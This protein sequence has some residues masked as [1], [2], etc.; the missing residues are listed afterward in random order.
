V[1]L[2]LEILSRSHLTQNKVK[3]IFPAALL[4]RLARLVCVRSICRLKL[5]KLKTQIATK[6]RLKKRQTKEKQEKYKQC[7]TLDQ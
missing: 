1:L 6:L 5:N 3:P 4:A 2:N 7:R